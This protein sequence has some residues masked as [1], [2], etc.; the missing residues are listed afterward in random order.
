MEQDFYWTEAEYSFP[1]PQKQKRLEKI[2]VTG[3]L[4]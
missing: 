1:G 3:W 4:T 2:M